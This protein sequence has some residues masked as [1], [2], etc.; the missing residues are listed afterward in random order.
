M[1]QLYSLG[2]S[3]SV[4]ICPL[5]ITLVLLL[6]HKEW[7]FK[8]K[9][10]EEKKRNIDILEK[11]LWLTEPTGSLSVMQSAKTINVPHL[12]WIKYSEIKQTSWNQPSNQNKHINETN[13]G[14]TNN[15]NKKHSQ[16][17]Q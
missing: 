5:N 12:K 15:N 16:I 6:Q 3:L 2:N 4:M 1:R 14:K 10:K 7:M 8:K 13:K 17:Q 11:S 9:K